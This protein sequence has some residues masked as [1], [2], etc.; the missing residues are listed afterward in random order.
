MKPQG[1]FPRLSPAIR[2]KGR[3]FAQTGKKE[4][5]KIKVNIKEKKKKKKKKRL[6]TTTVKKRQPSDIQKRRKGIVPL[7]RFASRMLK[8]SSKSQPISPR[9]TSPRSDTS[10][11]SLSAFRTDSPGLS[12]DWSLLVEAFS[13]ESVLWEDFFKN[14]PSESSSCPALLF[15]P[16]SS[17]ESETKEDDVSKDHVKLKVFKQ[18]SFETSSNPLIFGSIASLHPGTS[19]VTTALPQAA[20]SI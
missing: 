17:N 1:P 9:S 2:I 12:A 15:T 16:P 13:K 4:E 7:T 3:Y 11:S 10:T 6:K 18:K 8:K 19:V 14:L 20:A 5:R